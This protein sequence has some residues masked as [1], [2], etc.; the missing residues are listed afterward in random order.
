MR[1]MAELCLKDI[2][3]CFVCYHIVF[4]CF[5]SEFIL[6]LL[7]LPF[8]LL[9]FALVCVASVQITAKRLTFNSPDL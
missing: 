3:S 1:R 7:V 8:F 2:R 4:P 9:G 5:S 6:Y